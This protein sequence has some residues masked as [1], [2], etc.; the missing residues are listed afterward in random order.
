MLPFR[1]F[2]TRDFIRPVYWL[3][4]IA[5]LLIVFSGISTGTAKSAAT[6][7]TTTDT[8]A[9]ASEDILAGIPLFWIGILV[10]SNLLW[11]TVCEMGAFQSALY[12]SYTAS[13]NTQNADHDSLF[14]DGMPDSGDAGD[15]GFTNCPHCGK[16][17][18]TGE[19]RTCTHCGM[20][21]CSSCIRMMG[22][23]RKTLTCRDCYQ[24]K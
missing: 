24:K 5:I 12:D 14:E 10:F 2:I 18:P 22:L 15:E 8:A 7:D 4:V 1:K 11:R 19:L 23:V 17:V 16:V 20:E 6:P 9:K 13:Q 3:G 21:G